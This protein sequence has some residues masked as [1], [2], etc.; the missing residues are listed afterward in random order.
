M[1]FP[2]RVI[3]A[4]RE[5]VGPDFVVGIRMSLDEALSGGL[6][7]EEALAAAEQ[8]GA[9]G[10]DFVSA[11]RGSIESD[12]S[13]AKA[14]PSIGTPLG[15]YLDV[16]GDMRRRLGIPV[17]HAARIADVA[18]ARHALREGLLDLVGMTRAQIADPHLVAK[19]KAGQEDRIR[20]CVG[21][22]Y[23][24]DAIYDSGDTKCIH[25]PAAAANCTYRT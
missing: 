22:S 19:V 21:A 8:F 3:Q 1:A 7:S 9:D 10:I 11:I 18:T 24:L 20:P 16:T 2:R 4:V 6:T 17:M 23:C 15:P 13:L 5:A 25:N 12:A 14:I